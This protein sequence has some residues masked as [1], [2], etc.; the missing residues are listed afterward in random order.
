MGFSDT[1]E[2]FWKPID[3][4][5]GWLHLYPGRVAL[6]CILS[7][8]PS[9]KIITLQ[10]LKSLQD[11]VNRFQL[12]QVSL[13]SAYCVC[14]CICTFYDQIPHF[15]TYI[16]S[17]V[18]RNNSKCFITGLFTLFNLP[19]V[20]LHIHA[21]LW[22]YSKWHCAPYSTFERLLKWLTFKKAINKKAVRKKSLQQKS[23]LKLQK[24][25][26]RKSK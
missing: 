18:F 10:R 15:E 11:K 2:R 5:I 14:I 3:F 16:V 21:S 6:H 17:Q 23:C 9:R 19:T 24:S 4:I 8:K 1:Y 20:V 22:T 26:L 7:T 12:L 25:I 13:G